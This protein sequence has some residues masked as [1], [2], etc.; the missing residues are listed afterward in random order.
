[1][2][3]KVWFG[4]IVRHL[5][6]DFQLKW[7][8]EK[9]F[10]VVLFDI[11]AFCNETLENQTGYESNI[12][13]IE[14]DKVHLSGCLSSPQRHLIAKLLQDSNFK[15]HSNLGSPCRPPR[16]SSSWWLTCAM[17]SSFKSPNLKTMAASTFVSIP[18][19]VHVCSPNLSSS[20]TRAASMMSL[21]H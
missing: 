20:Q 5:L 17:G 21:Q 8:L 15:S 7:C 12:K 14:L 3:V 19:M 6:S 10:G 4:T 13:Y 16:F 1:M 9:K 18:L 11:Q 2:K